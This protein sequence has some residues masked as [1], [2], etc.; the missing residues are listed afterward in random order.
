MRAITNI[1]LIAAIAILAALS[2]FNAYSSRKD[3]EM[4]TVSVERSRWLT[5]PHTPRHLIYHHHHAI[6][7][8]Y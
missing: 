1:V 8:A 6:V 4:R 5:Y 7:V 3:A 2:G